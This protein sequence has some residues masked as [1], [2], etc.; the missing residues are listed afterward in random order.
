MALINTDKNP[1]EELE[2]RFN[3]RMD[4]LSDTVEGALYDLRARIGVLD[5]R[6]KA[7]LE[8]ICKIEAMVNGMHVQL[9]SYANEQLIREKFK[10]LTDWQLVIELTKQQENYYDGY[11]YYNVSEM[12]VLEK[13]IRERDAHDKI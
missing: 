4:R 11:G 13:M 9:E 6:M 2:A 1:F 3:K 10:N 5:D 7:D 12:E 8:K